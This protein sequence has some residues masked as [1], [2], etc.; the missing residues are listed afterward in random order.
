MKSL[1]DAA[2]RQYRDL[3][4]FAPVPVLTRAEAAEW[5]DAWGGPAQAASAVHLAA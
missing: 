2:V 3:G 4:Y 5:R 1:P